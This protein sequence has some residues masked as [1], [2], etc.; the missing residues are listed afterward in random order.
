MK[1]IYTPLGI[2]VPALPPKYLH[3]PGAKNSASEEYIKERTLGLSL[4]CEVMVYP[5]D[6][7]MMKFKN[8]I[9]LKAVAASPWL[10]NDRIWKTF[11]KPSA[12][13]SLGAT[14]GADLGM[15]GGS[16]NIG[17]TML[18]QGLQQLVFSL[19]T[20][21]FTNELLLKTINFN[22]RKFHLK[23]LCRNELKT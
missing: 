3:I 1:D 5:S 4:F 13:S 10:R 6:H 2:Y 11:M 23:V 12:T 14:V 7:P 16:D 8:N 19:K 21:T 9:F 22:T 18:R 17:E 20:L 15:D